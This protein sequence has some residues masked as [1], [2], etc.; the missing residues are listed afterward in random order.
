MSTPTKERKNDSQPEPINEVENQATTT[1]VTEKQKA[2]WAARI[3]TI[4]GLGFFILSAYVAFIQQAGVFDLSDKV[5]MP[6]TILM[7]LGGLISQRLIR[8]D[9]IA[10]GTGTV[11]AIS[12]IPPVVAVFLL[13]GLGFTSAILVLFLA[14]ILIF[15]VM[16][17]TSR[18]WTMIATLVSIIIIVAVEI[19]DP[20]YRFNATEQISN[21]VYILIPLIGLGL[22]VAF[23]LLREN[24]SA[25]WRASI[26]NRLTAIV[27]GAAIIPVLITS[28]I[29]GATTYTQVRNALVKEAFEK[30]AAV[31]KIKSNQLVAYQDEREA[32]MTALST[33]MDALFTESISKLEAIN[34][35]KHSEILH[36]YE[37]WDAD[38]RDVASDPGVVTGIENLALGFQAIGANQVRTLYLGEGELEF[39]GDESVYSA[40]HFEQH[41]F[42][43]GYTEIHGY[44]NAFLIDPA[45]NIV[46]NVHKGESFGTNLVSGPYQDTNLAGLYQTLLSA[47]AGKSYMADIALF[48]G[49]YVFFIGSP[50]YRGSTLTGMLVYELNFEH[51]NEIM[52]NRTGLGETGESFMVAQESDGR[53]TFRSDRTIIGGGKFIVG[54]DLSDI[55]PP[56]MKDALAGATGTDLSIGGT[57]AAAITAYSPVNIAGLNWAILSRIDGEEVLSP[58]RAGA[59][60]DFL[61]D[62]S[63]TYNYYDIFLIHPNGDIFYTVKHEADYHT[64]ILTGEYKNSGLGELASEVINVQG[65]EFSDFSF[66][67]PTGEAVPAAFYGIPLLDDKNEIQLILVAQVL[68]ED[69]GFVLSERVGLGETG[70]TYIVGSDQLWRSDSRFLNELGVETTVLNEDFKINTVASRSALAGESGQEIIQ[71]YRDVSVLS[72]WSPILIDDP[73]AGHP[74]GRFWAVIAEIDEDEALAPVN[75]LA[76]ILGVVIGLSVLGIS[77]L[78]VFLGSRFA[79]DFVT[80]ILDLTDRATQVA[81]G[82]LSLRFESDREDE[83]GTLSNTFTEM[84]AQ[85]DETLQ[86]LEERVADRTRALEISTEVSRRLSTILDQDELVKEV[87]EQLVSAFGYYYAH[88]YLFEKDENTLVMKGGTGEAGKMLLSRGHTIPKGRGLVGRAAESNTVVLVGDTLNE[89]GWLPNELLPETRSE[90]AVPISIGDEVLGV[91]DVQHNVLKGLAEED[92]GLLQS[93]ANQ[94]AIALQNAQA[95]NEAQQRSIQE[96]LIG[97]IGQQIQSATTVENALKVAVRE[98]G[99]ALGTD[100]SVKLSSPKR[101]DEKDKIDIS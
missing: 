95:Y 23:F 86:G 53:I 16:P 28:I 71:D 72:V 65:Y 75:Q 66:Y 4:I 11:F 84:T 31:Q 42:F 35:L 2:F 63:E 30:L 13:R 26:R 21:F 101:D 40:A 33:T 5:L 93:I 17:K 3:A 94:V 74:D 9:R 99:R 77:A 38:V 48:D 52:N 98:L 85:L 96:A 46:Y 8:N 25:F 60:K 82:D 7:F 87:V 64:N 97:D 67:A 10:L 81:G 76:G 54:Y 61:T 89:E 55:A 79:L 57:G 50:T 19:W 39:A 49:E 6:V 45:G 69:V 100:A 29:L 47:E 58:T 1:Q 70:E 73:D 41:G 12:L 43:L 44:K 88:I 34:T 59:E 62:Y 37:D 22:L 68:Q 91:F 32:D 27:I 90:I 56:F 20:A 14:S 15:I 36:L 18:R 80:P 78:A 51:I 24:I 83:I 92:A